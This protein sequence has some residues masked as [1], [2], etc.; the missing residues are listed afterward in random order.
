[1]LLR[2]RRI[3]VATALIIAAFAVTLAT[4]A[5]GDGGDA[6]APPTM[7][8]QAAIDATL[9]SFFAAPASTMAAPAAANAPTHT[10]DAAAA[11]ADDASLAPI[12]QP[13][14]G[15]PTTG[16]PMPAA[17]TPTPA[18][19]AGSATVPPPP[20]TIPLFTT[21]A[22]ATMATLMPM[23]TPSPAPPRI[24]AFADLT[25]ALYLEQQQPRAANA[26]QIL[27]WVADGLTAAEAA[28]A[29]ELV[30]LA[31]FYPDAFF[32]I[33]GHPWVA[34]GA[35]AAKTQLLEDLRAIAQQDEMAAR[36]V[37]K[38]P[39][40]QTLDPPDLPAMRSLR[41]LSFADRPALRRILDHPTLVNGINDDWAKI[42]TL[43]HGVNRIDPALI[44]TLL[45]PALVTLEE[46]TI[47]L[48]L[49]GATTLSIIRTGPGARRSMDLLEASVRSAEL[50]M[51]AP[52][53]TNYVA[54]LYEMAVA[55]AFAGTNFGTHI[56]IRPRYDVD[57]GSPDAAAAGQITAHEVAHYY[58]NG[59][60][61]WVDEGASDFL[62]AVSEFVRTGKAVEP[63]NPP[64]AMT[65][66]IQELESYNLK[67]ESAGFECSYSLGERLFIDLYRNMMLADFQQGFIKLYQA[68]LVDDPAVD[69]RDGTEVGIVQLRQAFPDA[70]A[71]AVI[72]RWYDGSAAYANRA[73]TGPVDPELPAINGRID[74]A[75]I[76][77]TENGPAVSQFSASAINSVVWLNL[78][79]SYQIDAGSR[80]TMLEI[81][82]YY[83]DGFTY[84]RRQTQLR[85]ESAYNGGTQY[86]SVGPLPPERWAPGRYWVYVHNQGRKVAE[87]AFEVTP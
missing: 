30:N 46:R 56:V 60:A 17:P 40:L 67:P 33:A 63:S 25:N 5:C 73:D 62:A 66:T 29:A 82:E 20:P 54:V 45:N 49:S 12:A 74:A 84:N 42:V 81:A 59:N 3:P 2:R 11:N 77:I 87:V 41:Q 21:P 55:G 37:S 10:A 58:W 39:F 9:A 35:A 69:D 79:F 36:R 18:N 13:A 26:I 15:L 53:P 71:Q 83:E 28:G 78:E 31:A 57:D 48:P 52:L 34:D 70:V 44:G 38:M 19:P 1:M 8:P 32:A 65:R 85:V 50:F 72:G 16:A 61:G 47:N 76:S 6:N 24:V 14:G 75:H 23:P 7:D 86:Y 51:A 64:C 27:P 68:S 43:L 4:A 22:A 80:E